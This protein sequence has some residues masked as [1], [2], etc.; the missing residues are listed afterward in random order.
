MSHFCKLVY[1]NKDSTIST[2]GLGKSSN[3]VHLN[4]VKLPFW[5]SK[6]LEETSWSLVFCFH[7]SADITFIHELSNLSLHSSPPISLKTGNF[8]EVRGLGILNISKLYGVQVT[9]KECQ[10]DV[11]VELNQFQE[12]RLLK[13]LEKNMHIKDYSTLMFLIIKSQSHLVDKLGI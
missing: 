13:G 9:K 4:M 10:I 2:L 5:N 8:I 3:E 7:P 6:R 11:V 1:D 12:K